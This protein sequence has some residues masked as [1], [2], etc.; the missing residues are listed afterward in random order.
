MERTN[1]FSISKEHPID[2][3]IGYLRFKKIIKKIP[4]NSKLLDLGCGFDGFF[5]K[6]IKTKL[7]EGVGIDLNINSNINIKNARLLSYAIDNRLPFRDNYF[8]IITSLANIEHLHNPE[9]IMQEIFRI[10]K[11]G[12]ILLM[13]TPTIYAKPLLEF[14]AFKLGIISQ[15]EI[16]D[17]KRYFAKKDL[18]DMCKNAGF[19]Q[20][21][22]T[23]FQLFMNGFL[24]AKK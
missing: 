16:L 24:F 10:L 17:H 20:Y 9:I 15:G 11:P 2:K 1:S 6:K 18:E 12:G 22:Y 8:D 4:P 7:D 13:T 23:Y 14:M 5:L 19:L 21:K 3:L